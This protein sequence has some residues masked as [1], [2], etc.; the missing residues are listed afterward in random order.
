[1]QYRP[2]RYLTQY[3][4]NLRTP[5]GPQKGHV[6]DVNN[7]GARM[8]GLRD[9]RRGDKVE[10]EI[11]NCRAAAVVQWAANGYIGITFR[12]QITDDQVDTLRYRRDAR[13]GRRPS[14]HM[15]GFAEMR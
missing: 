5:A 1:M 13:A 2:H 10:I 14:S 15:H 4:A 9:L 11:L 3:P 12:P 7:A 6:I 8:Q